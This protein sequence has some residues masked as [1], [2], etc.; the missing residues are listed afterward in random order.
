MYAD[1]LSSINVASLS[2]RRVQYDVLFVHKIFTGRIDSPFL[3]ESFSLQAS[4]RYTR[5][6]PH[7]IIHI[8]FARVDTV[9]RGVFVRAPRNTNMFVNAHPE[10]DAL[11]D[12]TATIRRH[13]KA[14]VKSLDV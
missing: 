10:V 4:T 8:P 12:A 1:L 6:M 14:H 11:S 7:T 9:K 5:A 13:L 2:Q 3:L